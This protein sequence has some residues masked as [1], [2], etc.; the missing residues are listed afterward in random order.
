VSAPRLIE[1]VSEMQGESRLARARAETI[2]LVPTM[3]ALHEG[4]LSLV[5]EARRRAERV[6]VSIFVNPLQFGPGE[7]FE[8]Y[9]RELARDLEKL[10]GADFVFAPG[11]AEMY[12]AGFDTIVEVASLTRDLE[13]RL[14]P[15]HFRGVTTVVAKLLNAVRPHFAIFGEKD[16]QQL[17][18]I[19]R[20]V[21]DLDLDV[22]IVGLPIVRDSDGLA[23]S[24]RN[25]YLS[26][27]ERAQATALSR[28]LF[29]AEA[30]FRQG[31]RRAPA[32]ADAMRAVLRQEPDARI[33]YAEVRDARSLEAVLEIQA[34][35]VCLLAVRIGKTRLIDNRVLGL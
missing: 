29:R 13:G 7:D 23:L 22:E 28:A 16:Y 35:V 11:V 14:R 20:M 10:S 8:A 31:E 4:H 1:R 19:R 34:P 5:A 21:R 15:T 26:P 9:P 30:V 24:S 18:V 27:A 17:Q 2:A 32:L 3:G 12:P 25:V 33:D 6:V